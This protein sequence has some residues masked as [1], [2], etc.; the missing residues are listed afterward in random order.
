MTT[1]M[2]D[3]PMHAFIASIFVLREGPEGVEV[4]LL[5]R[6]QTLKG[7]WCQVAGKI[8]EG[9]TAWQAGLRELREETG[10][11][12]QRYY[13]ADVIEQ[14][15]EAERDAITV[16]PV[17]VAYVDAGADVRLN[18]EHS[19]FRWFRPTEARARLEFGGQRR[20]LDRIVED[21]IEREP[22]EWLRIPL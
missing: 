12:P 8:E 10:L 2:P 3:V 14:F 18:E 16:G 21:F 4:L 20:V 17:F 9:E 22:S 1:L 13:S 15:Y 11:V 7:L 5:K 6:A 19:D